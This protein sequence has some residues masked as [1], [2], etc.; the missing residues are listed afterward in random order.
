MY[1]S[2]QVGV[3]GVYGVL[4]P[5]VLEDSPYEC[6][7]VATMKSLILSGVN[8]YDVYF[9]PYGLTKN[10]YDIAYQRNDRIITLT[11]DSGEEL[12][13]PEYYVKSIP[14]LDNVIYGNKALVIELGELPLDI[15]LNSLVNVI[16]EQAI[17]LLGVEAKCTKVALKKFR[18]ITV[19]EHKLNT[20]KRKLYKDKKVTTL[21]VI[22]TLRGELSAA[23]L[24]N[25]ALEEL[26][27]R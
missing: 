4:P 15:D 10:E 27:T 23:M 14:L 5:F 13:L 2:P 20:A 18:H 12:E 17:T 6:T 3:K 25:N 19:Q 8:V 16:K 21:K 1:L 11:S 7:N 26:L 24:R 22:D 9:K